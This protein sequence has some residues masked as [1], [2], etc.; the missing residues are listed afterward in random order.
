MAD[1]NVVI[2]IDWFNTDQKKRFISHLAYKDVETGSERLFTF[3]FPIDLNHVHVD[4]CISARGFI[5]Q[6]KGDYH[7]SNVA[8]AIRDTLTALGK[9][10]R[11]IRFWTK[12]H[13]KRK[14]LEKYLP[15]VNN[16]EEIG[17]PKFSELTTEVQTT[18]RKAQVFA[19]WI[20]DSY[21]QHR[22][23]SEINMLLELE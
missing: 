9:D 13:E 16:L 2:E 12:G 17:C 15:E 11:I 14:L 6:T 8:L 7:F 19:N 20:N 21:H 3:S 5:W 1:R 10:H 18:L 22:S 4:G 23:N